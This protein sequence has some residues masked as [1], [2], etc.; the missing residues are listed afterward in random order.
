MPSV[1]TQKAGVSSTSLEADLQ[2]HESCLAC[3]QRVCTM[4][5]EACGGLLPHTSCCDRP[6][7]MDVDLAA[8]AGLLSD[9]VKPLFSAPTGQS[10]GLVTPQAITIP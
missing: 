1:G 9:S 3:R 7:Y 6:K 4:F 2:S 8:D 5:A 10:A